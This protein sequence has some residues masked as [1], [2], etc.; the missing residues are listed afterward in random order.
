MKT[1]KLLIVGAVAIGAYLVLGRSAHAGTVPVTQGR[2]RI[3]ATQYAP[4]TPGYAANRQVQAD[5]QMG[6][7]LYQAGS[8][9]GGLFGKIF[10]GGSAPVNTGV[11]GPPAPVFTGDYGPP[12]PYDVYGPPSPVYTGDY[13]PPLPPDYSATNP[14]YTAPSYTPY[15][16]YGANGFD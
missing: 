3:P 16:D 13:G 15:A 1:E 6:A 11:Y 9:L 7:T 5:N 2:V 14:P 4:G 10:G 8:A 12:N